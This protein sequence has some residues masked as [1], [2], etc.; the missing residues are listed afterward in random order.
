MIN[1]TVARPSLP[2]FDE[3]TP[4]LREIWNSQIL[5]NNGPFHKKFE[6][7]LCRYLEVPFIS[8][9]CNATV[10]LI[11]ALQALNIKGEVI[12][13]PYS[14]VAT[15]HSLLWNNIKPIFVDIK[16]STMNIDPEKIEAAITE[17]TTAI[18]PVH[19]Y[20][21]PCDIDRIQEI[22][23]KYNLKIIYDSAHAFGVR[24]NNR[25][26][27]TAGDLS[28]ISFHATKVFNT[29]EGG[30]IISSNE[31]IKKHIDDLKNF[32]FVNETEVSVV[33]INGK[34]SEFNAALGLLQ[35]NYI[36]KNIQERKEID[37][38]YRLFLNK[39][40]KI[41]I[42]PIPEGVQSNYSYFPI[43]F[44]RCSHINRDEL[45]FKLK[46]KGINARRYFHPLITDFA[47]YANL[48][49]FVATINAVELSS[50]VICLPI[51]PGLKES[52]ISFI[53]KSVIELSSLN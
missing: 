14:F 11:T 49:P 35:L 30:A 39:F 25:S 3:F 7:E 46:S 6:N 43:L 22:A 53:A 48:K 36:D 32:G 5:T 33:G 9:F 8:V 44:E 40:S 13:T 17:R 12:T 16:S 37:N 26:I 24:E 28:V 52:D 21:N 42:P 51:Y 41:T 38:L 10:A 45:Y 29:F 20:G 31:G 18:L 1:Y 19:C 50:K 27:L 47:P 4:L 2:P 34:M 15:A 23:D